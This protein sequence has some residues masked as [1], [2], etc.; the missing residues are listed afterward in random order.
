MKGLFNGHTDYLFF[1]FYLTWAINCYLG[2][3]A[4][5]ILQLF[6]SVLPAGD[7]DNDTVYRDDIF[8]LFGFVL[9]SV[10]RLSTTNLDQLS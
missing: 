10:S 7:T 9:L 6:T 5:A 1:F 3:T 8:D 4:L 2:L